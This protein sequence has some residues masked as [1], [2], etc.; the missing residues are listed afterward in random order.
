VTTVPFLDLA[1]EGNVLG[2][3]LTRAFQEVVASGVYLLGAQTERL[4]AELAT[5]LGGA[6]VVAVGSGTQALELLLLAHGI[7]PGD[8]VVTTPASY[9]ATAKA[10]Q[11]AGAQ[12]VF[13]DVDP[14]SFA[15]DPE[16]VAR[17][18]TPRTRA[19]LAV[20]LYGRPAPMQALRALA[21]AQDLLL[22]Q[23][24]AQSFGSSIDDGALGAFSHG[25]ILSFYPT[26]NLGALG[27]AGAIFTPDATVAERAASMRR[28]GVTRDR[29]RFDPVGMS[30]RIDELQ[31]ALLLVKLRH[32]D[33]HLS[34]R[35]ELARR[36]STELPQALVR[37]D[38]M[39]DGHAH[40][41]YTI[42]C[43]RRDE[44]QRSLAHRAIETLVH[45]RHPLHLQEAFGPV[46]ESLPVTER[47]AKETLSLPLYPYLSDAEQ[48]RVIEAVHAWWRRR[49]LRPLDRR[50]PAPPAAESSA[51][52]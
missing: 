5:C 6:L 50:P 12:P 25:G 9:Y 31:A 49:S 32:V 17:R 38:A 26:K 44:L 29:D 18:L 22:L 30:A 24:A 52:R 34:V 33:E 28:L 48:T 13:A 46:V 37:P 15:L 10:V 39:A 14:E 4:E 2:D 21:D 43:A 16:C 35:R 11:L 8:E 7:G 1:R 36:Y 3:E 42:R 27:D 47:W 41:L 51:T 40:H 23:D 20:D 45:Y 19:I